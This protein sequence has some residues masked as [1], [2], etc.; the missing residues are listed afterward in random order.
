MSTLSRNA[1]GQYKVRE[2]LLHIH[3][4]QMD[5]SWLM[6]CACGLSH[7]CCCCCCCDLPAFPLHQANPDL[8]HLA[9]NQ[10]SSCISIGTRK[11]YSIHNVEPFGRVYSRGQSASLR[12]GDYRPDLPL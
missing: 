5:S 10:D 7:R 11:G 8:L 3:K 12:L 1:L 4:L 9:F 6:R 2:E